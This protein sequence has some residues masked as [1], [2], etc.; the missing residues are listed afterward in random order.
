MI[1]FPADTLAQMLLMCC[2]EDRV[3][4]KVTP[5]Y[6]GLAHGGRVLPLTWTTRPLPAS[7]VFTQVEWSGSRFCLAETQAPSSEKADEVLPVPF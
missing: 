3:L 5:R 6:L 2:W 7:L 4:S 1:L